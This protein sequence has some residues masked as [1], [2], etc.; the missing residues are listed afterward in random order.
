MFI[1]AAE[2]TGRIYYAS[3]SLIQTGSKSSSDWILTCA[4][5]VT[6]EDS[7]EILDSLTISAGSVDLKGDGLQTRELR[8]GSLD[9][10]YPDETV[11]VPRQFNPSMTWNGYDLYR[12]IN[13]IVIKELHYAS[14]DLPS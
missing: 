3:G 12:C 10:K 7:A 1:K 2:D 5:C 6:K 4:H 8:A 9:Y 14:L 11:F 13:L